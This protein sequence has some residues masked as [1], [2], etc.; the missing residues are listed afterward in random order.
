MQTDDTTCSAVTSW[1]RRDAYAVV[2]LVVLG[3]G[4]HVNSLPNEFVY[5]D[6]TV[7]VDDQR[8]HGLSRVG[9]LFSGGYWTVTNRPLYR[10]VTLLSFAIN[11]AVTGLSAPGYRAVNLVLHALTCVALYRLMLLLFAR[12][13]PAIVAGSF[14][15]VHPIHV[16]AVV[17]IVGR[18]E[19]LSGLTVLTAVV[20]YVHDAVRGGRGITWRYVAVVV[21]TWAAMLCK[22][23]AIVLIGMVVVYDL[24]RRWQTP[25]QRRQVRLSRYLASRLLDRYAGML[26]ALVIV[27]LM[28]QW[29]IGTLFGEGMTFSRVDNPLV[30]EPWSVRVVTGLVLFGKYLHLLVAGHPLCCDYSYNAIP[31]ARSITAPVA[32][33]LLCA[34]VAVGAI[35]LSLR[36]RGGIALT[37]LWYLTTYAPVA[38]VLVLIGT[39]FAERLM[40]MPSAAFAAVWGLTLPGVVG[41]LWRQASR[42]LRGV[43]VALVVAGAAGLV[44]HATLTVLRNRAWRDGGTIFRD[45][46]LKQPQSAR[47][48]FNMGAW[49][50][51]QGQNDEAI[52]YFRRAVEIADSYYLARTRLAGVYLG[53]SRWQEVIEVL[54]PLVRSTTARNEHLIMPLLMLGQARAELG[55]W[56]GAWACYDRVRAIDSRRVEAIRCQAEIMTTPDT[57][58]LYNPTDGWALIQQAVQLDPANLGC[59]VSAV[60]IALRQ[61]RLVEADAYLKRAFEAA[62][63]RIEQ[64][65]AG[66]L[67]PEEKRSL[68]RLSRALKWM[69]EELHRQRQQR[70]ERTLAPKTRP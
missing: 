42:P 53:L 15:A 3:I 63:V 36:R 24:W 8:S 4:V 1:V 31:V 59:L 7:V 44:T 35:V 57:G 11:H 2:V 65:R 64:A 38:N 41:W 10:P 34:L 5:D 45:A 70:R 51:A 14:Y 29:A 23:N 16:E 50:A 30:D 67:V 40:Y 48:Q 6:R 68:A 9:E 37:V 56:D 60:G 17:P 22:E 52:R 62:R 49:Y 58:A 25:P 13:W 20:L 55:Q 19:L 21:L 46:L 66:G 26:I 32:W 69:Q 33:G 61:H 18:S 28:R 47:C 43:A 39:L 12:F 27:F 54:E